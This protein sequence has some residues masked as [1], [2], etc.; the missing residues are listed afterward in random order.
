MDTKI[1]SFLVLRYHAARQ[2]AARPKIPYGIVFDSLRAWIYQLIYGFRSLHI[3]APELA[4]VDRIRKPKNNIR[5]SFNACCSAEL[6]SFLHILADSLSRQSLPSPCQAHQNLPSFGQGPPR[7]KQKERKK[8]I[9]KGTVAARAVP[10]ICKNGF[11][12]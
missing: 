4:P 11:L 1:S 9:M 8:Y 2:R 10:D 3:E 7:N 6:R 12:L 5:V